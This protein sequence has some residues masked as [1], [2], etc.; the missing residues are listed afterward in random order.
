MGSRLY[1]ML[2]VLT[3]ASIVKKASSLDSGHASLQINAAQLP[4]YWNVDT[5]D[6]L[7]YGFMEWS[8]TTDQ[9]RQAVIRM[10]NGNFL[11]WRLLQ[12]PFRFEMEPVSNPK[13][14]PET[15]LFRELHTAFHELEAKYNILINCVSGD[16]VKTKKETSSSSDEKKEP[17]LSTLSGEI[18]SNTEENENSEKDTEDVSGNN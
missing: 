9:E 1:D 5:L 12:N 14:L 11:I 7:K 3:T 13:T 2:L 4:Q 18:P 10:P 17:E 16:S 8:F 15:K 6:N